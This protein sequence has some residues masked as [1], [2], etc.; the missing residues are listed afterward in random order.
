VSEPPDKPCPWNGR[1]RQ[2]GLLRLLRQMEE[3]AQHDNLRKFRVRICGSRNI[4]SPPVHQNSNEHDSN[5]L[6]LRSN[7]NGKRSGM[8]TAVSEIAK[9]QGI[10]RPLQEAR[11]AKSRRQRPLK[12]LARQDQ[13]VQTQVPSFVRTARDRSC[14]DRRSAYTWLAREPPVP[15]SN[16]LPQI[17]HCTACPSCR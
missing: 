3:S 4:R 12:M 15:S 7:R 16:T 17:L 10:S 9:P 1:S 14:A 13:L 8:A 11:P 5:Q 6:S 2:H